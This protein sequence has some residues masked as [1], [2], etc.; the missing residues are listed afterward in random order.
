MC[1]T[2]VWTS[3]SAGLAVQVYLSP[4]QFSNSR[5]ML[6]MPS[7]LTILWAFGI[8]VDCDQVV[9]SGPILYY[10]RKVQ[11]SLPGGPQSLLTPH[12]ASRNQP[13]T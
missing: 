3:W 6:R 11:Q 7:Y 1:A 4:T 12:S 13:P 2:S 9:R 5:G 8:N 10:G